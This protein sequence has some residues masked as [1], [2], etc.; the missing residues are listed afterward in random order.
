MT[1]FEIAV[2]YFVIGFVVATVAV[3]LTP[4]PDE[5]VA[6]LIVIAWP[7]VV[8]VIIL[9]KIGDA[10]VWAGRKI[11]TFIETRYQANKGDTP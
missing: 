1:I 11:R 6:L 7:L 3:A 9:T 5:M 8:P 4:F 10:S 2:S